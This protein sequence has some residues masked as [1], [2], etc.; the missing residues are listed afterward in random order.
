M[1]GGAA[2]RGVWPAGPAAR[3]LQRALAGTVVVL[4]LLALPIAGWL[5]A[6]GRVR[7]VDWGLLTGMY[8]VTITGI[9]VGFHRHFTH[10]A[11]Q[12]RPGVCW[13]L[14]VAGSMAG[15]GPLLFWISTHRRHHAF[16][17]AHGDP[18]SPNGP[19]AVRPWPR[20]RGWWH[21]HIGWM[22][23]DEITSWAHYAPDHLRDPL[24]F[25]LHRSYGVWVLAGLVLPAVIGGLWDMSARGAA[26]GVL[27]G[28]LVRMAL[29][30]NACWCVGSICHMYGARPFANGDHSANHY[31]VALLTFGEGLQNNHHAFPSSAHHKIRWWEPDMGAWVIRVLEWAGLVWAVRR[32]GREEVRRALARSAR[33]PE[34]P[35]R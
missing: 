5:W 23:A 25:R 29:C 24:S 33:Q 8:L 11:F 13:M 3:R 18:H 26:Q 22:F 30:N 27:F 17:D 21:A 28:G 15:Q 32:P 14:G 4:P 34:E 12:A 16:S 7:P 9:T 19:E 2:V 20:L 31:P 1:N 35:A 6:A 10:G